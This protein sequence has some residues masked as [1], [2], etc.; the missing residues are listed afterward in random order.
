MG[1]LRLP[2]NVRALHSIP[3]CQASPKPPISF[4]SLR[5]QLVEGNAPGTN[6]E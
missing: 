1:T 3:L 6:A 2:M 5:R 4:R